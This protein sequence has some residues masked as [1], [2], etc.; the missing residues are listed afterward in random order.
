MK[1]EFKAPIIEIHQL[2]I[3]NEIMDNANAMLLST[4]Q[5]KGGFVLRD[6]MSDVAD[7]NAWKGLN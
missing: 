2:E 1:K 3:H 4:N 7:Y 6:E 5:G